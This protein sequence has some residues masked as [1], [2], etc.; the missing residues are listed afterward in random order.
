MLGTEKDTLF[1]ELPFSK[2]PTTVVGVAGSIRFECC[3][4]LS[5]MFACYVLHTLCE[6][7][8][9]SIGASRITNAILGFLIMI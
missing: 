8:E 9:S 6:V 1:R 7:P 5:C 4:H 3:S 2:V